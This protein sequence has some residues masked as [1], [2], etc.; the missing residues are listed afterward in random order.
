[1]QPPAKV[2]R[3]IRAITEH[4]NSRLAGGEP[5]S[6]HSVYRMCSSGQIRTQRMGGKRSELWSTT[7][8]VDEAFGLAREA[9]AP[10]E[11][12]VAA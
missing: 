3:G 2:L 10:T 7:D 8:W 1:M 5:L 9:E 11:N 12:A 4:A 6:V